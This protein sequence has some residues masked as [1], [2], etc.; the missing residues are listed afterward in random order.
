M[1]KRLKLTSLYLL[2]SLFM[3]GASRLYLS[4]VP[5]VSN[6]SM[7][8]SFVYIL[9]LGVFELIFQKQWTSFPLG[10]VI[11]RLGMITLVVVSFSQGVLD[12]ALA[13]HPWLHWGWVLGSVMMVG[14]LLY[15]FLATSRTKMFQ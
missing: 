4:F 9:V 1:N 14:S 10:K 11:A 12:I 5:G 2:A 13:T 15:L 3:W 7:E 6:L 8:T